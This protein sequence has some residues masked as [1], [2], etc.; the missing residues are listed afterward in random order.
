MPKIGQIGLGVIGRLYVNHLLKEFGT[1]SVYDADPSRA[2]D[3][4]GTGAQVQNTARGVG[5]SSQVVILALPS[6]QAV[7]A[8]MTGP[9][10]L[11]AGCSPGTIVIDMSTIDPETCVQVYDEAKAS[12]VSYLDAPISGGAP[13]G[14]GTD[15]AKA[16]NVTFMVGGDE[17]AFEKAKP[18]M[19]VLG[20]YFFYLGASGMGATVK[21]LSNQISGL[22][23]LICAETFALGAAA[24]IDPHSLLETFGETD[25][26][27]YFM[28]NYLAPRIERNDYKRGFSVD[29]MYKDHRLIGQLGQ[30]LGVPLLFNEMATQMYQ[31]M[32]AQGL[33][34]KDLAEAINFWG[35]LSDTDIN[36]PRKKA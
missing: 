22:I 14:A 6:P 36:A 15:G 11:L 21:L 31:M 2:R 28:Q 17:D 26:D 29:L 3:L 19:Q 8:A 34:Q 33:G 16:A 9:D 25:A 20:S 7:K 12:G 1:I 27:S 23:N 10:G 32:R 5:E 13:R 35:R 18:V 24:G 30:K 4:S